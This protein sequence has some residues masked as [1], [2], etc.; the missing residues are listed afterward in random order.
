MLVVD[1]IC[2]VAVDPVS[3]DIGK[4]AKGNNVVTAIKL[5]TIFKAQPLFSFD[6]L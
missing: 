2:I 1:I 3:N 5:T 4:V 6:L